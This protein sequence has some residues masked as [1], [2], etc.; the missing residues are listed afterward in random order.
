MTR[1]LSA[2]QASAVLAAMQWLDVNVSEFSPYLD[3]DHK[4]LDAARLKR[5]VE[6]ALTLTVVGSLTDIDAH[7]GL[8]E[9]RNLLAAEYRDGLLIDFCLR[10]LQPLVQL[11]HLYLAAQ[12]VLGEDPATRMK[13][14]KRLASGPLRR[15]VH[16]HGLV[17]ARMC[18][19]WLG[20]DDMSLP[21][22]KG[23]LEDSVIARF[24]S[25]LAMR[26]DDI[27]EFTHVIMF[28]SRYGIAPP[29]A[30]LSREWLRTIQDV[31]SDLLICMA[32]DGHWD[33]LGEVLLCWDA[34]QLKPCWI[35]GQAWRAFL[36]VQCEDGSFPPP[37]VTMQRLAL[38]DADADPDRV[39][40]NYHTTLVAVMSGILALSRTSETALLSS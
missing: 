32:Q 2:E 30:V 21:G 7:T 1:N 26:E 4:T 13:I 20:V 29:T 25:A 3:G 31:L 39:S 8:A 9:S 40:L 10:P 6:L 22:M 16:R 27:Y 23:L 34:L 19:D 5:F 36:R 15:E 17:E 11:M 37:R 28:A 33:L 18:L 38:K 24:R 12:T 14:E 35:Q